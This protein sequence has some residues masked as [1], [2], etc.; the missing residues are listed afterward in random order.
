MTCALLTYALILFCEDS[1][2]ESLLAILGVVVFIHLLLAVPMLVKPKLLPFKE[3]GAKWAWAVEDVAWLHDWAK[4]NEFDFLGY[5]IGKAGPPAFIAVWRRIDR[6]TFLCHYLLR[7]QH[8]VNKVSEIATEFAF[9]I[10]LSTANSIDAQL[11]PKAPG[12]Y[13]QTFSK[14]TLDE[15]WYRHIE[16]ENYLMDE[17]GAQLVNTEESF[18]DLFLRSEQKQRKFVRSIP[19]WPFLILYWFFVRKRL[20]HGK[21]I[22]ELH[23]KGMIKWPKELVASGPANGNFAGGR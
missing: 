18:E 20:W 8:R 11:H 13:H 1:G 10:S 16:A 2:L 22:R 6:P 7:N 23:E 4:R 14:I 15:Q 5:Y 3:G 9:G 19:F 17:G 12:F 21:S